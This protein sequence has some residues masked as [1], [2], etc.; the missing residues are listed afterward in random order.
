[1][2]DEKDTEIDT[3]ILCNMK[4]LKNKNFKIRFSQNNFAAHFEF[5]TAHQTKFYDHWKKGTIFQ[6]LEVPHVQFYNFQ[7]LSFSILEFRDRI[8]E[9]RGVGL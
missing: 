9:I 2:V 4:N 8:L 6:I 1:M 3:E 7:T 5:F